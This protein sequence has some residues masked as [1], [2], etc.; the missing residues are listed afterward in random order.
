MDRVKEYWDSRA[1]LGYE[2][3]GPD[4]ILKQLEIAAIASHIRDGMRVLDA[5]CGNGITGRKLVRGHK[6]ELLGLDYSEPMIEACGGD[7]MA[8]TMTFR[9]ADIR[10][11]PADIGQFDLIYTERCLINLPDWQEQREAVLSL[12]SHL[13]EGGTYLMCE[14]SQDGLDRINELRETIGLPQI[15]QPFHNRYLRQEE[16]DTLQDQITLKG[17]LEFSSTYYLF[18]R[19]INAVL[20]CQELREPQYLDPVNLLALALPNIGDIGQCKIWLWGK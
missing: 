2:A 5:G 4:V 12:I 8:G 11:L 3:G 1:G 15:H 20:A 16:L 10:N 13:A 18:S 17:R 9:V 19:V 6:I 14:A 7:D